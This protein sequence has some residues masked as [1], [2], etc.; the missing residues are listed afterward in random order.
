MPFL[1][2]GLHVLAA[3]FFAVHAIRSGQS[4]YWL[5]LL[6][7]FPLLGSVVYFLA[8]YF[9]EIRHSRGARQTLRA[10]NRLINPGQD[11]HNAR[12]ELAHAPTLQNRVRLASVL[13]DAGNVHEA[14]PLFEKAASSP[15]GDEPHILAGLA[16]ARLESGEAALA[17]E[18]LEGMFERHPET[19]RQPEQMLLYAEALAAGNSPGARAAFE[20]AVECGNDVAARCRYAEWLLAQP[21]A[22]DRQRAHGLFA[23]IIDDSGHWS[24]FTRSHHAAWLERAKAVM[25]GGATAG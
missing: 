17:V 14:L 19:R 11:L 20:R 2:I 15:L 10:A 16:R 12:A 9:P 21:D 3:I 1:G 4:L 8:I 23:S 22:D 25:K 5:I 24:R 7:S 18:A 13:L 6:F